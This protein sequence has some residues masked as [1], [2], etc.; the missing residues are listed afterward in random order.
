MYAALNPLCIFLC[1]RTSDQTYGQLLYMCAA[2]R[3]YGNPY[4]LAV[5]LPLYSGWRRSIEQM[6]WMRRLMHAES[7]TFE[8]LE[9]PE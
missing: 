2:T 9:S 1:F 7:R 3:G 6:Q 5:S 8:S 4:P